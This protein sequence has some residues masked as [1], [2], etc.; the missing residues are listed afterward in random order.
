MK[1]VILT[2]CPEAQLIDISHEVAAYA[3]TEAAFTLSQA[4]SC[5]PEGTV[6]LVVV[7]PAV[8]STCRP[9]IVKAAGHCF[10]GPDNGV[11]TM[12]YDAAPVH[13]VREITESSY[14]RQ[15]VSRTF[16][17]RDIFAPAAAHLAGGL[18]AAV[19]GS[20]INDYVRLG[21]S[22]PVRTGENTWAGTVLSL[23]TLET[24]SPT[25]METWM[26]DGAAPLELRVGRHLISRTAASYT[27]APADEPFLIRGSAGFLE[28]SVNQGSAARLLG[29]QGGGAV[30][31]RLRG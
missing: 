7:D 21:F 9:I 8:G 6:H 18:D 28:I 11:L 31:L 2:I 13:E 19:F 10:V 30:E 4:W 25:S 26:R 23:T 15:P 27:E 14:F 12:V 29:V 20:Q 1:G 22:K 16:H 17:G 3:I 5:F 24:R